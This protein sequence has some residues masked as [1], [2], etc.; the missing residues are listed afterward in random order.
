MGWFDGRS[1]STSHSHHTTNSKGEGYYVRRR[2]GSPTRSKSG[3]T[4]THHTRNSA[5][6]FFN[7]GRT[8]S[9]SSGRSSPT[10]SVFSAFSSSSRR[11]RPREGFVQ[12]M[13]RDVKRLFR[14]IIRYAK[15]NPFKVLMLVIVPLLTSGVLPKLLAM[16]GLRLPHGVMSAL[17]GAGASGAR[18]FNGGGGGGGSGMSENLTSLMNIAKMFA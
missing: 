4:S 3:Y 16:V 9:R 13:I 11:A 14:D 18:G 1:S 15:K 12:R 2:G 10:H 7:L 8:T 6:S 17:G 5:P